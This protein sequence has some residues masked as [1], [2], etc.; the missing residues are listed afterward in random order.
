M[1]IRQTFRLWTVPFHAADVRLVTVLRLARGFSS[2]AA[3]WTHRND[4]ARSKYFIAAQEDLY[5]TSEWV[6]FVSV[7]R[8]L[9]LVVLVAQVLATAACVLAQALGAPVSWWEERRA[10]RGVKGE[11]EGDR[12]E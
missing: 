1:S 11:G 5:Q 3:G 4:R 8:V 2:D 9:W 10:L 6:K 7:F 12:T